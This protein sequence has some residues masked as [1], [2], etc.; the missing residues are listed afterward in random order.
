M[1]NLI[2]DPSFESELWTLGGE[3]GPPTHAFYT[4]D[5]QR[6]GLQ[7]LELRHG[8]DPHQVG[9]A[10]SRVIPIIDPG[11]TKDISVWVQ[12]ERS[13]SFMGLLVWHYPDGTGMPYDILGEIESVDVEGD[14]WVYYEWLGVQV[15][16]AD[17]QI[18]IRPNGVGDFAEQVRWRI[19]DVTYSGDAVAIKL[20]ERS[21]GA[22]DA[23]LKSELGTELG[24]IDVERDDGVTML[25]PAS[26]DYTKYPREVIAGSGVHIEVFEDE[27][28]FVN[29]FIDQD[30]QRAAYEIEV[31]IKVTWFNGGGES[32]DT[33]VTRGRRYQAGIFNCFSK[34]PGLA[35]SDDATLG[36]V[37]KS[38]TPAW[39]FLDESEPNPI[40]GQAMV[41]A[42]VK[43]TEVQA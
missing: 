1:P 7:A 37:V 4:T 35:D 14:T 26:A 3:P 5:Y 10:T 22:V 25:V 34:N 21:V 20:G 9:N 33:M 8:G 2:Q 23:L 39:A 29:P 42:V 41:V 40:K 18:H 31:T 36:A 27:V 30:A 32:R 15:N 28:Q 13:S 38:V 11:E 43:C 16:G 24:L 12:C 19:D 17:D 6:T